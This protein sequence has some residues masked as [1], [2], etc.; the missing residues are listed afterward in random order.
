MTD[1][2]EGLVEG[3]LSL[4]TILITVICR[5]LHPTLWQVRGE[6]RD[7]L[8]DAALAALPHCA[9]LRGGGSGG[10]QQGGGDVGGWAQGASKAYPRA[11]EA[12][13]LVYNLTI[14][15]HM[16]E[17][18]Y[19][20]CGLP[21]A[22]GEGLLPTHTHGYLAVYMYLSHARLQ[23]LS[24]RRVGCALLSVFSCETT[25]LVPSNAAPMYTVQRDATPSTKAYPATAAAAAG[26]WAALSY[27]GDWLHRPIASNEIGP[28]V[29]VFVWLSVRINAALGLDQPWRGPGQ[30]D[31]PEHVL[32]EALTWARKRGY[33]CELYVLMYCGWLWIR[34]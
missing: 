2:V 34:V 14:A 6:L 11:G 28:L 33:R 3:T 30:E 21:W 12:D 1:A 24:R 20:G 18:L 26:T 16:D 8:T 4:S 27:K 9:D 5:S 29:R 23:S 32:A 17:P 15:S 31:P 25:Y 19:Y 7:A 22:S 13:M 10:E